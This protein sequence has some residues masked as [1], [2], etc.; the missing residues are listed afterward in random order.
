MT[1]LPQI[2]ELRALDVFDIVPA[3]HFALPVTGEA[4][5]PHLRPGE[6]AVIDTTDT[7]P[8]IGELFAILIQTRDGDRPMIVQ[9][10]RSRICPA[11]VGTMYR[12]AGQRFAGVIAG[13]GPLSAAGWA[14][15]C[16]GRVVGVMAAG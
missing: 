6:F 4:W 1:A 15:R 10:Y 5:A 16:R 8:Q 12:F 3:G 13:D 7:A 14:E 2:R 11:E 9:S